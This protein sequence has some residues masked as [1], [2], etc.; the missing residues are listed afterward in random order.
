M[1]EAP[2]VHLALSRIT[3][4]ADD[5]DELA[6]AI[7]QASFLEQQP[8]ENRQKLRGK[9]S[10]GQSAG[11]PRRCWHIEVDTSVMSC[12]AVTT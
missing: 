6:W 10:L 2:D 9:R 11:L 8:G 12:N 1:P 3:A 7:E 4:A 5:V